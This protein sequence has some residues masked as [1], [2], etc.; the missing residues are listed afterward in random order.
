MV[1]LKMLKNVFW[2]MLFLM[3]VIETCIIGRKAAFEAKAVEL[4]KV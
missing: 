4:N 1:F 2:I 3:R